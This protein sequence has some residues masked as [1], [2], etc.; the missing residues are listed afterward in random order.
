LRLLSNDK[1]GETNKEAGRNNQTL[2]PRSK[3]VIEIDSN[4]YDIEESSESTNTGNL[5][6]KLPSVKNFTPGH[7]NNTATGSIDLFGSY[8]R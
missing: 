1:L 8:S 5:I 4:E 3:A 6:K 2:L 7:C